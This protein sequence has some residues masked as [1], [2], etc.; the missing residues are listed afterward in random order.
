MNMSEMIW[1]FLCFAV[2]IFGTA[3]FIAV[4]LIQAASG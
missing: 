3:A 4:V 2:G 1:I